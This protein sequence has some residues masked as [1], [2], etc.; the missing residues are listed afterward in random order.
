RPLDDQLILD[1]A[2]SFSDMEEVGRTLE[3][4][5]QADTATRTFVDVYR[6]YLGVQAKSD[7]D[8]VRARLDAVTHA[9]TALF[10]ATALRERR[11]TER[12]AG[13][14]RAEEADRAYEQS[15][16]DRE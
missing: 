13:E 6:K 1:A 4:L 8:Q 14:V 3:G 7:V 10:A 16:A 9:S 15:L 2:R 11:E 5:V 12:A